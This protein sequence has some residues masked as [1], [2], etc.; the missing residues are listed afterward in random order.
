MAVT[1]LLGRWLAPR[2]AITVTGLVA[3]MWSLAF[4]SIA[5]ARGIELSVPV[6]AV[7]GLIVSLLSVAYIAARHKLRSFHLQR[8]VGFSF[9]PNTEVRMIYGQLMLPQIRDPAGQPV[10]H[11]YVKPPRRGPPPSATS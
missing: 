11:P 1:P 2:I 10:T 8:L 4:V 9:K 3:M 6:L 5:T 7:Q